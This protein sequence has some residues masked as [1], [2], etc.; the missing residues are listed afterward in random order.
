MD[1]IFKHLL[2]STLREN[3]N[4]EM[5]KELVHR[6]PSPAS[7]VE[8]TEQELTDIRGIGSSKAKQIVA[9]VQLVRELN[10]PFPE[11]AIIRHPSDVHQLLS[12]EL[13]F[14]SKENF[15]CLFL[16]T[17]N[18]VI[19]KEVIST[20]TLNASLV[21]PREVFRAAIKRSSASIV[22]AHNHPSG[23]PSPSSEDIQITCR[24]IDAGKIIGID[25][26]DHIII[27]SNGFVSMKEQGII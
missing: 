11:P 20:G 13:R 2:A 6:Y 4:S 23:D 16:N 26:I 5:I 17:K 8:V 27:G 18:R 22:C 10:A 21:H 24:L 12:A 7:L 19:F 1:N 15:I 9:A 25:V 14:A 3:P